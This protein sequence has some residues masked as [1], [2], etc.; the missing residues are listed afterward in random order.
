MLWDVRALMKPALSVIDL[1]PNVHR[2]P[3]LA[4]LRRAVT[5]GRPAVLRLSPEE[6]ELAFYDGQVALI[7]P[8][9]AR[10]LLALYR[11]GHV[12]LKKPAQKSLP[13]LE[14]YIA[15]EATFRAEVERIL[16]ADTARRERL[17]AIIADPSSA[18]PDELTPRLIDRV[19]SAHIG[20][21]RPGEMQI[22]G[23][24]CHRTLIERAPGDHGDAPIHEGLR[25]EPRILCW[26]LDAEGKR[27]GDLD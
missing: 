8:I 18:R 5:D 13:A 19:L 27:Q 26:W 1:I 22:A 24:S 17:D 4:V 3:A 25:A 15:T 20:H 6:K 12:K 23:L 16:A 2:T 7:S 9:G 21:G 14:A 11:G 10:L